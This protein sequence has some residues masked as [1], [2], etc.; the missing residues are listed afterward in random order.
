MKAERWQRVEGLY[1][2]ALQ[3]APEDR[4][5]FLKQAC[6]DD[7]LRHEVESLLGFESAGPSVLDHPAWETRLTAGERLGPYEVLEKIGAGGMGE[8]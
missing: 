7:D 4:A 1:H 2:A 6:P 5:A 3:R 8:V